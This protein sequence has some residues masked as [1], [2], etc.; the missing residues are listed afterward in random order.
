MDECLSEEFFVF[1]NP[2][3]DRDSVIKTGLQKGHIFSI[4]YVALGSYIMISL[5]LDLFLR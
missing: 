3:N 2:K 1:V 5:F 4:I